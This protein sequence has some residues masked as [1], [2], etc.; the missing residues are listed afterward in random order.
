MTLASKEIID[1]FNKAHQEFLALTSQYNYLKFK[2][3][4]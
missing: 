1:N 3:M 2:E 4:K